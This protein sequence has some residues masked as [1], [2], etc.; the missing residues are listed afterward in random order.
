MIFREEEKLILSPYLLTARFGSMLLG[1]NINA[2]QNKTRKIKRK[3][4]K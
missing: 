2:A 3:K 4:Y 1:C